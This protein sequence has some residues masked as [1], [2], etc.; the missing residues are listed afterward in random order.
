MFPVVKFQNWL[1]ITKHH[2]RVPKI[3]GVKRDK[4]RPLTEGLDG[5]VL[6]GG[7]V[8]RVCFGLIHAHILLYIQIPTQISTYMGES[9]LIR[10][11]RFNK[12]GSLETHRR[13]QFCPPSA[14]YQA[15]GTRHASIEFRYRNFHFRER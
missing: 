1:K 13:N 6:G 12:N 7:T 5:G 8:G 11:L 9:H 2:G 10:S 15:L 4:K 14:W 3:R